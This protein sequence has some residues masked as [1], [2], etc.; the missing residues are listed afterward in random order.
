MRKVGIGHQNFEKV[1]MKH[2]FYVDK[3]KFIREWWESEDEVTLLTRPRRFGKTLNMSMLEKFF[4]VEY[5]GRGDLFEGLEI[6]REEKYRELQ[7][8]WPVLFV[9]FA[10]VKETSFPRA[11][12]SICN[13]IGELYWKYEFLLACDCLNEREKE[14][15]HHISGHMDEVTAASA[16]RNLSGQRQVVK[17]WYDGFTFGRISDIY[18][19][20]S[21]INYLDKKKLDTYWANT[22]SNSLAGKLIREGSPEIKTRFEELLRGGVLETVIDEQI[23]FS[24]LS[25]EKNA[26]WSLL[27]AGGYLK[28]VECRFDEQSGR[29]NYTLSLT[30][31]EVRIMFENMIR[32]WFYENGDSYSSFIRAFLMGDLDAMNEYM[33]RVAMATFSYFDT[34]KQPSGEEPKRIRKYGFCVPGKR[35]TDR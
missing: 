17:S 16:L 8:T 34:E 35:S 4:S 23:V 33:N 31:K 6:W 30:N 3:T 7:G 22:S 20:W 18:N 26:V 28:A 14:S 2:I 12:E 24:Q 9:S 11:K 10:G 21:I 1:R 15:W 25:T 32:N 5:A 29:R 13:I 19:P 27:L